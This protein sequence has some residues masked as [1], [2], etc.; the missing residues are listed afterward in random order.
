MGQPEDPTIDGELNYYDVS[1]A[2]SP[3]ALET[4]RR[5]LRQDVTAEIER[6][7]ED[8][9]TDYNDYLDEVNSDDDWDLEL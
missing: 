6:E 4:L 2:D 8:S 5:G 7:V 9:M 1:L 3:E